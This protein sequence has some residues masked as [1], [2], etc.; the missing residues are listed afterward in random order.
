MCRI[1][2][3]ESS[4]IYKAGGMT[5][6]TGFIIMPFIILSGCVAVILGYKFFALLYA[7]TAYRGGACIIIRAWY[8]NSNKFAIADAVTPCIGS[9]NA[10]KFARGIIN[11]AST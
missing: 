11:T 4:D 2:T 10:N 7:C 1:D 3:L 6:C 5:F 8:V 9:L